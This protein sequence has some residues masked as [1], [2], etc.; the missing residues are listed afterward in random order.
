MGASAKDPGSGSR[1][2]IRFRNPESARHGQLWKRLVGGNYVYLVHD[3]SE[4]VAQV[5]K[6]GVHGR[7]RL[8]VKNKTHGIG[9]SS[10][11]KRMD[12]SGRLRIGE[13]RANLEHVR[14]QDL[15]AVFQ[16]V[17]VV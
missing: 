15:A 4:V 13:A 6:R 2:Q 16:V 8:R 14:S 3:H 7:T 5:D 9:F 1:L 12:L 11:R 17:C 10:N